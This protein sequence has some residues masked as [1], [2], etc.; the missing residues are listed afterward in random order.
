MFQSTKIKKLKLHEPAWMEQ[1]Q[2]RVEVGQWPCPWD[3]HRRRH[4]GAAAA[5][6]GDLRCETETDVD[7][8]DAAAARCHSRFVTTISRT[9]VENESRPSETCSLQMYFLTPVPVEWRLPTSEVG[10]CQC[11]LR[12]GVQR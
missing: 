7:A 8:A 3:S 4:A 10:G 12:V 5:A 1:A 6:A 2:N 9:I 11:D